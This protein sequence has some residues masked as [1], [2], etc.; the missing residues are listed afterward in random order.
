[1][2]FHHQ[3]H[4]RLVLLINRFLILLET[5]KSSLAT[6]HVTSVAGIINGT[7]NFILTEMAAKGREFAD[8]LEEAQ[9]LGYAEADPTFDV[10]NFVDIDLLSYTKKKQEKNVIVIMKIMVN[11]FH[12]FSPAQRKYFGCQTSKKK[13]I[14][15]VFHF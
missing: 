15:N 12:H 13:D 9:A 1:M 14:K 5:V 6:N 10:E 11:L 7:G 3:Y 4:D 8:V 2:E